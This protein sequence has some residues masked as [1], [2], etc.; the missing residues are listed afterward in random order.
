[1]K[2]SAGDNVEVG[3]SDIADWPLENT[4]LTFDAEL[5]RDWPD[6]QYRVEVKIGRQLLS[7]LQFEVSP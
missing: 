2:T 6:G 5:P 4:R 7:A 1:V 3:N